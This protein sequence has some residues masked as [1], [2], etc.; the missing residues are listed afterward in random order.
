M[1]KCNF[2]RHE[3]IDESNDET[4]LAHFLLVLDVECRKDL[5]YE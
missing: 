2:Q 4:K 3:M 1:G 5:D